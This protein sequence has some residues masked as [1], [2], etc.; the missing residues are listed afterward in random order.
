MDAL[1]QVVTVSE[2]GQLWQLHRTT[3]L[4]HIL[5]S[6]KK[7]LKA[8][9]A[10]CGLWLVDVQSMIEIYGQPLKPVEDVSMG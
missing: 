8:R 5:V 6:K 3:I 1:N 4:Y 9:Q 2:A 7:R 10:A